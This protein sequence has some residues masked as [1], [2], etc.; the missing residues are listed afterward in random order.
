MNVEAIMTRD[1]VTVSMDDTVG[2]VREIF[3]THE[4]HH[5]VV[6]EDGR[7]VGVVSDRDLLK[8]LSPFVGTKT[9]RSQDAWC[10]EKRVHQIMRRQLVS[11]KPETQVK[12]AMA[13]LMHHGVTCLPIVD[14]QQRCHGIVTWHDFMS[15]AL[16]CGVEPGAMRRAG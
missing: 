6:V 1:V 16:E 4:F 2:T 7:V 14:D 3:H 15:Y 11:V 10:L 8:N 12:V 5:L 13:L 9:E